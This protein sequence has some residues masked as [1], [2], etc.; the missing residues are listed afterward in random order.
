MNS[1]AKGCRGEREFRDVLREHGFLK[2]YRTQ[3]YSGR[4]GDACDVTCPELPSIHWEVKRVEAGN[5]YAWM[6]QAER[7]AGYKVEELV[8]SNNHVCGLLHQGKTPIIAHKRNGRE[9][10]AVMRMEDLLMLLKET[11]R[12]Q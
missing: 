6:D 1:R 7:D 10:L 11:D 9:W 4:T 5:P 2:S 8:D 3:Q 12:V